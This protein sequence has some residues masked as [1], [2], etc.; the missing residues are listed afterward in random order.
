MS[1]FAPSQYQMPGA[2]EIPSP[3]PSDEELEKLQEIHELINLML[4]DIPAIT[5]ATAKSYAIPTA[6]ANPY[7]AN[8]YA[9]MPYAWSFQQLPWS[10]APYGQM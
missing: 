8:P 5:H 7:S 1:A 9:A 3:Q 10:R 6:A 2:G 4:R